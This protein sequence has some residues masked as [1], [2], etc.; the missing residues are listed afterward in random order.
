MDS[1]SDQKFSRLMLTA[2]VVGSMVGAG[3]FSLPARFGT[4]TGLLGAIIAWLT[5]QS[6]YVSLQNSFPSH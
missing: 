4:A 3:I 1:S 6:R 5:G 2:M